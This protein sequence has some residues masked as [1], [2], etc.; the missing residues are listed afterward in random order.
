MF[1]KNCKSKCFTSYNT[2]LLFVHPKLVGEII[3]KNIYSKL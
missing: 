2:K 3:N 1:G